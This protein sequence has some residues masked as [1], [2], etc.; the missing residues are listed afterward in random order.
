[1]SGEVTEVYATISQGDH[2]GAPV[3]T[4]HA[5]LTHT[6]GA[7]SHVR[8]VWGPPHIQFSTS[9]NVAGSGGVLSFDSAVQDSWRLDTGASSG[10]TQ[11]APDTSFVESPYL[12]ELRDF[13]EAIAGDR[14]P[15]VNAA[16]GV[17]A[18][19]LALAASESIRTEASVRFTTWSEESR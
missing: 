8:G 11:A 19:D 1:V 2:E 16:D 12:T 5:V 6:N 14:R 15:S 18:L 9:F 17:V 7:I 10:S 4:A 13:M 3:S